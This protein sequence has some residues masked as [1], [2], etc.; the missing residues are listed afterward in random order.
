MKQTI[1]RLGYPH[2]DMEPPICSSQGASAM[3]PDTG[4]FERDGKWLR[5]PMFYQFGTITYYNI[6]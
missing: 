4:D 2:D 3:P 1:Q 6:I 5:N